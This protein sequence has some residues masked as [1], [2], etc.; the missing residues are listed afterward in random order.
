MEQNLGI[1]LCYS[2]FLYYE[3]GSRLIREHHHGN[4]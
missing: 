1:I 4:T 2:E 3:A